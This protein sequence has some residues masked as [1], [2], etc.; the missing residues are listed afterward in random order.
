LT[1]FIAKLPRA[2]KTSVQDPV[3]FENLAYQLHNLYSAF[4]GMFRVVA[5]HFEKQVPNQTGWYS[6]LLKR[7]ATNIPGIRPALKV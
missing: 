6:V 1:L 4:E 5:N 2:K 7:M 3:A